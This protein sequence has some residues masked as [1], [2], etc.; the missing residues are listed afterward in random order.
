[1]DINQLHLI[2][3]TCMFI[4]AKYIEVHPI[5]LKN[6]IS[7]IAHDKFDRNQITIKEIEILQVL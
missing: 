2:G 1:M 7:K 5:S 4:S 3:V 6:V